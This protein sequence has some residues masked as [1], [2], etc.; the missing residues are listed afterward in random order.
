MVLGKRD[1]TPV[2]AGDWIFY[3]TMG[4]LASYNFVNNLSGI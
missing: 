4:G 3:D 1:P 2:E